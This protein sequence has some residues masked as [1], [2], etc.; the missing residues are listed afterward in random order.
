MMAVHSWCTCPAGIAA[1]FYGPSSFS[2]SVSGVPVT[3]SQQTGY[4][5][6]AGVRV[7]VQVERPVAFRLRFRVPEWAVDPRLELNGEARPAQPESGW[8][9]LER[10]WEDGDCVDVQFPL[11]TRAR[12]RRLGDASLLSFH[13][14]AIVLAAGGIWPRGTSAVPEVRHSPYGE[15]LP[16][17]LQGQIAPG[18]EVREP[19]Y[20]LPLAEGAV[21]SDGSPAATAVLVPYY[22]AGGTAGPV[23]TYFRGRGSAGAEAP[24]RGEARLIRP[25]R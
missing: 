21:A 17:P 9:A 3:L 7:R 13:R 1:V 10:R 8:I 11:F 19:S 22:R 20:A 25:A 16:E 6:G 23:V 18:T 24:D 2:T 14:G 15:L 5:F 4:P 12:A